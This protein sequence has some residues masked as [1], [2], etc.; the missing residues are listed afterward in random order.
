MAEWEA[1]YEVDL[2]CNEFVE[3]KIHDG[4][5]SMTTLLTFEEALALADRLR[6]VTSAPQAGPPAAKKTRRVKA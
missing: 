1:N 5:L 4:S 3:L 6:R 2:N